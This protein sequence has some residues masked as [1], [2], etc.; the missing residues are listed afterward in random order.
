[1][2]KSNHRRTA[3]SRIVLDEDGAE[4]F[5]PEDEPTD[6]EL[7]PLEPPRARSRPGVAVLLLVVALLGSLLLS[8]SLWIKLERT[9]DQLAEAA[10][11]SAVARRV[12]APAPLP[13][14][15]DRPPAARPAEA[16][17]AAPDVQ[18]P[19]PERLL[20]LLTVGSRHYAEKQAR[21][22]RQKCRAPLAVY[23][24]KRGRCAW[25]TCFAV[26]VPEASAGLARNCGET[27]GQSL[28]ETSDFA[29]LTPP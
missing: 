17:T 2:T 16:A 28:R 15:G 25:A 11:E 5:G 8:L 6:P 23:Q 4:V 26:A 10:E 19:A 13:P 3:T 27:K 12:S 22:L 1:V 18:K 9:R 7:D 20:L 29:Q 21:E 24:Q 14:A